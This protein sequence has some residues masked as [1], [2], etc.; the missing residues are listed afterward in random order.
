PDAGDPNNLIAF[1]W[2]DLNPANGGTVEYYTDGVAPNRILV[3]NFIDVPHFPNVN[4][5]TSQVVLYETSNIIQ[6]HTTN[7]PSDGGAHTM[8]IENAGGTTAF[9]VS[10]RNSANWSAANDFVAFIPQQQ[11][12]TYAWP[13]GETTDTDTTLTAGTHCVTVTDPNGCSDTVCVTITEPTMLNAAIDTVINTSCGGGTDGSITASANGGTPPYTF[14]WPSGGT[15]ATETGLSPGTYCVTV[16]D[17]NNCTDTACATVIA[18]V[19][20]VVASITASTD[21]SCNGLSD[22]SATAAGTGGTMPYTFTWSNGGGTATITNLA[23]GTY[24]VTVA[25]ANGCS[26]IDSV[27]IAEPALLV[28]SITASTDPSCAANDGTATA[29]GTG[30]TAPY[31]FLWSDGQTTMMATN[32]AAGTFTVTITDANGCTDTANVVLNPAAGP[33]ASIIAQTNVSCNG[34]TDGTATADGTGGTPPYN[35]LWPSGGTS[36][37]ETGLAVGTHC[38]TVTDQQGCSDVTCVTIS[39]PSVLVASIASTTD[40]TC[41]GSADGNATAAGTGGSQSARCIP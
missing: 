20:N 37:T 5:V 27:T 23:A 25:D 9:A 40:A 15:N 7:M 32:L 28:A 8:G 13:S 33:T 22:G 3:V 16:T 18:P 12:F 34:A 35:F 14:L 17:A 36:A 24:I 6:I 29:A 1:A 26:D 39:A 41:N 2:E 30:G 38:V 11:T 31:N 4:L 21:V 10:G 19:N